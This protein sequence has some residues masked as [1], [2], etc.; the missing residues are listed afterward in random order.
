V[1]GLKAGEGGSTESI[2]LRDRA[3][4]IVN[5]RKEE[6]GLDAAGVNGAFDSSS[7]KGK[8][9]MTKKETKFFENAELKPIIEELVHDM[10]DFGAGFH[11]PTWRDI[12]VVRMVQWPLI[13]SQEVVWQMKY[14]GRRLAR[15]E[16]N[17]KEKEVLTS[18]AVGPVAWESASEASREEMLSMELWIMDNLE[19]WCELQEVRQLS[20]KEQKMYR[21]QKKK[22][23][24]KGNKGDKSE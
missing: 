14:Y 9:K 17:D 3:E 11:Q 4:A 15:A 6:L 12:L 13:L 18:R 1:E 22:L 5:Q 10:K 2:E 19:Q 21:L 20:S 16:L 7:K 23:A 24:K 8:K